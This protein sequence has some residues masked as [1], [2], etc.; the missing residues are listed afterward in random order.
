MESPSASIPAAPDDPSVMTP[1]VERPEQGKFSIEEIIFLKTHLPAF[2]ALCQQLAEQ[3]TG[4]RG[5]GVIKGRKKD[6]I[7]SKVFPEFVKQFSSDQSGGPQL[8]SLQA[9]SYI[10]NV[11]YVLLLKCGRNCC[12]GLR[13]T[14]LIEILAQVQRLQPIPEP[15]LSVRVPPTVL[16]FLPKSTRRISRS[17]WQSSR[18]RRGVFRNRLTSH[19]IIKSSM[20]SMIDL[21]TKSG[22]DMK[23]KQ[24]R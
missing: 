17:E 20:N 16:T 12:G 4:P 3:A 22:V 6:W 14:H 10:L 7:L 11:I 2:G 19:D 21:P 18:T 8:Q 1:Q 15:L 5:T 24:S 13:I 9:V 23:K